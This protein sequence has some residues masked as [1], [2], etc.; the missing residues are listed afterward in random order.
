MMSIGMGLIV[1]IVR[2]SYT[3]KRVPYVYLTHAASL[4]RM[5]CVYLISSYIGCSHVRQVG[6]GSGGGSQW[7]SKIERATKTIDDLR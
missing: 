3:V 4:L 2:S 7:D 6:G 5:Y 1:I